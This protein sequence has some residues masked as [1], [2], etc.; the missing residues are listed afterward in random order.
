MARNALSRL[1]HQASLSPGTCGLIFG[2][3]IATESLSTSPEASGDVSGV[4]VIHAR[5]R[6]EEGSRAAVRMRRGG[7]TPGILFSL[8]GDASVLVSMETKHLNTLLRKHERSGLLSQIFSLHLERDEDGASPAVFPVLP[9]IMHRDALTD[10]VENLTLMFCPPDRVVTVPVRVKVVGEELSPGIKKGGY[11][12]LI[13]RQVKCVGPASAIPKELE[14]DVSSLDFGQR[15]TISGLTLPTGVSIRGME[16]GH[17]IC[18]LA[19]KASN[20]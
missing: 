1:R 3:L 4:D 17:P 12:N 16:A 18:K 14:L 15:I 19:G 8:P 10:E 13:Q 5:L 2:R 6:H 20:D 9:R 7:R 11:M